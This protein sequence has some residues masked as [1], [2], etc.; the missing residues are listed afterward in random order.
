MKL[1]TDK[2]LIRSATLI[3]L[4][5]FLFIAYGC[6]TGDTNTEE[7]T[8]VEEPVPESDV[9]EITAMG[10]TFIGPD[11]LPSGWNTLRF[12]NPSGMT[13]FIIAVRFPEGRGVEDHQQVLAPVFQNIMDNINGKELSAPEIGMDLPEWSG[14]LG[15]YGGPGLLATGYTSETTLKL[16]PGTYVFECYVKSGGV[17]H[18]YNPTEGVQGMVK[19]VIVTDE[20]SSVTPPEPTLS[21]TISIDNGYE[22]EGNLTAGDHIIQ[23]N[24][25]DQKAYGNFQGH[26]VHLAKLNEDTNMDSLQYWMS[27]ANPGGLNTPAPVEFIGG[28][29]EMPG[30]STAYFT[31]TLE[32][33]QRYAFIAEIPQADSVNMLHVFTAGGE[34]P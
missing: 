3:I 19:E 23:V 34:N 14:E 10:L 33:G 17:F 30:G 27:W 12:I 29:N 9:A 1:S 16:D 18:S 15:F 11:T 22:I 5:S 32:A 21:L 28:A 2:S 20:E 26:D 4:S 8:E 31:A 24:N 13:H 6:S 25:V 7:A